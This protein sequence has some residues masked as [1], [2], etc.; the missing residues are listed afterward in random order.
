MKVYLTDNLQMKYLTDESFDI[1]PSVIMNVFYFDKLTII[2]IISDYGY[3]KYSLKER[4]KAYLLD[5]KLSSR[6][7]LKASTTAISLRLRV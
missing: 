3:V 2:S 5:L 6:V 4:I 7:V 1:L